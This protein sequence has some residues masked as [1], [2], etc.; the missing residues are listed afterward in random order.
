MSVCS[1]AG[2]VGSS[3]TVTNVRRCNPSDERV[4][5]SS[6]MSILKN[7]LDDSSAQQTTLE[8]FGKPQYVLMLTYVI[9][10]HFGKP[11]AQK[12]LGIPPKAKAFSGR[13]TTPIDH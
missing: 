1:Y 13:V 3:T 8:S 10:S 11:S 6:G 5:R 2:L 12:S 4:L 7:L 9:I